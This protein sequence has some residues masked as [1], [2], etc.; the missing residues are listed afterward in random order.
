MQNPMS[1]FLKK[2]M[3][4][5]TVMFYKANLARFGSI[6][7]FRKWQPERKAKWRRENPEKHRAAMERIKIA[8]H[9]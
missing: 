5:R 2:F 9:T 3:K 6:R 8:R 4:A 7:D 1:H